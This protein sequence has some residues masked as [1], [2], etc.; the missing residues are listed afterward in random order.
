MLIPVQQ[1]MCSTTMQKFVESGKSILKVVSI[2][3]LNRVNGE[4]YYMAE[5]CE[6]LLELNRFN[7]NL[8]MP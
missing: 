6:L 1:I 7:P 3:W 5:W 4:W 2:L 8:S